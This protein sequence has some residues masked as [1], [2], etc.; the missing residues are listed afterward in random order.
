MNEHAPASPF[1]TPTDT[2]P[3]L[4]SAIAE[5]VNAKHAGDDVAVTGVVSAT[6]AVTPGTLFVGVPGARFHGASFADK[7]RDAGAVALLTGELGADIA[8][9]AGLPTLVVG[10]PR[11]VIADVA[12][13][14]YGTEPDS[15]ALIGVTGTDGKTTTTYLLHALLDALDIPAALS[16]TVERR[17]GDR[18][19]ATR[20][21]GRLTTPQ[22]DYLHQL[23]AAM[24]EQGTEVA[25]IEVSAQGIERGR[26][27]GLCFAIAIFTNL[28]QDHLDDYGSMENNFAAKRPLF[29]PEHARR[30]VIAV[31]D[32]WG[33]RLAAEAEIPVA[34]VS[35][36]PEI[37]AD[38]QVTTRELALDRTEVKLRHRD[39]R[40]LTTSVSQPGWFIAFDLALAIV[41][42]HEHGVELERLDAALQATDGLQIELPGRLDVVNP[43]GPGPR[44]LVDYG[45]TP[46]SFRTVLTTLRRFTAG[47]LFMVFGADG[48]R[49][50]SKRPDMA[51]SAAIADT[52]IVTDYN[53]RFEDPDAIRRTLVETLH[54][55]FPDRE[56]YEIADSATGIAKAVSLANEGDL[57]F[58]GGHGHRRDV[59]VRGRL[60][61]YSVKDAARAALAMHGWDPTSE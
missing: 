9:E 19:I 47:R 58:V 45:H 6:T 55:E 35:H 60:I 30:G 61:P 28:T 1:T 18:S 21:S 41:A 36:D 3:I 5:L 51:R 7:A 26:I 39:G 13:T 49:D 22:V 11:E 14:V 34:T 48:D 43:S 44:I 8:A 40:T 27:E 37:D 12:K 33:Q 25:A 38:W 42:L 59:E 10:D 23:V 20:L 56:V 15:P 16:G 24:R 2:Q 31:N 46:A 57:I 54:A 17:I 52:I 29:T 4:L 53:P 50:P 32:E